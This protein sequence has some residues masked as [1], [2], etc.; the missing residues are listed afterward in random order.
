M[1]AELKETMF[2]A[3]EA[4]LDS[5]DEYASHPFASTNRRIEIT[6]TSRTKVQVSK[7]EDD[8]KKTYLDDENLHD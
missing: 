7:H 2:K 5:C 8:K 3:I 4:Y 6:V 1:S